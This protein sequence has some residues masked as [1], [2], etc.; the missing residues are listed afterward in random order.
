MVKFAIT[1]LLHSILSENKKKMK[2]KNEKY[3]KDKKL[4]CVILFII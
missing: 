4:N 2:K 1:N 3:K